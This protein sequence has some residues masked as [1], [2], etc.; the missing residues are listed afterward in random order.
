[1]YQC[2]LIPLMNTLDQH[3]D[4]YSINFLIA[5]WS[6]L[7]QQLID[8]RLS[9]D[10]VICISHKWFSNQFTDCCPWCW[11]NANWGVDGLSIDDIDWGYRL[12]LDCRCL[13]YTWP[14]CSV[15]W[16]VQKLMYNINYSF[17]SKFFFKGGF[18]M[19]V[20]VYWYTYSTSV[21]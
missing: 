2:W 3:L 6:T 1:M 8:S 15:K 13:W 20:N 19:P 9:V 11:W 18:I 7:D 12:T 21:S 16:L 17:F 14:S 10:G 5:S 4:R